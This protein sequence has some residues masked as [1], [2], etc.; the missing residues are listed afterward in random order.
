VKV[1]LRLQNSTVV[2]EVTIEANT[3]VVFGRS[4]KATF[5]VSDEMMSATHCQILLTPPRLEIIDL[6]SK[7]G[8][9]LN[10][11]RIEQAEIF[12]GDEIK[13]GGTKISINQD[14]LDPITVSALTFPGRAVDRNAHNLQLDFTGARALN[15]NMLKSVSKNDKRPTSGS[16]NKEVET[17]IA[18]HSKIKL[19]KQEI[20][21]KFKKKSSLASTL[22]AV[23]MIF[24][25]AAPLFVIN[26]LIFMRLPFLDGHKLEAIG[27][28]VAASS[29]FVYLVNFK[30]MKFTLGEKLTG[31]QG[32][33]LNQ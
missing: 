23:L 30:M 14:K 1:T 22:D 21:L 11:I 33:Y 5:K 8:T 7:N 13:I 24:S 25:L 3:S 19:S 16:I 15:Q 9:Y 20:R 12:L 27:I 29:L 26:L 32:T 17:R 10:G 6:S 31:I 18:A 2:N 28:S 4:S